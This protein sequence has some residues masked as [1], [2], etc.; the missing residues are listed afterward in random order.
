MPGW[1]NSEQLHIFEKNP[2]RAL[3]SSTEQL[4]ANEQ[5]GGF[6]LPKGSDYLLW[7]CGEQSGS[8][9]VSNRNDKVTADGDGGWQQ[10]FPL[11]RESE[12]VSTRKHSTWLNYRAGRRN[13][14]LETC[15]QSRNPVESD[16][17]GEHR[18][19]PGSR[20]VPVGQRELCHILS[21]LLLSCYPQPLV[22]QGWALW[23]L[24]NWAV[25]VCQG[26]ILGIDM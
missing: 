22:W 3:K 6:Q 4:K 9:H 1:I 23:N 15:L 11:Q 20:Q 24:F 7:F 21:F 19:A 5:K 18:K 10:L 16:K 25:E 12:R 26:P 2:R 13:R 8:F 14:F 17:T